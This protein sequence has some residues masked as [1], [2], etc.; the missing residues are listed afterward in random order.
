MN[1][2]KQAI[3]ETLEHRNSLHNIAYDAHK[4]KNIT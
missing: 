3:L 2:L 4:Y 1:L